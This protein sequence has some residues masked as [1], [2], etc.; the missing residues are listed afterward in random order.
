MG[1][2]PPESA[3]RFRATYALMG[4]VLGLLFPICTALYEVYVTDYSFLEVL[5]GRSNRLMLIIETAPLVLGIVF[6]RLGRRRELIAEEVRLGTCVALAEVQEEIEFY[7]SGL[8]RIASV[9]MTEPS[10][11]ITYANDMFLETSGY[12]REELMGRTHRILNSKEHPSE[13]FQQMWETI[14]SGQVWRGD[15]CNRSKDGQLYWVDST[16][17]PMMDPD[18]SIHQY[19]SIR[20]DISERKHNELALLRAYQEQ[21]IINFLLRIPVA[22]SVSLHEALE[23][24]LAKIISVPWLSL[25]SRGGIFLAQDGELNL[26]VSMGLGREVESRCAKIAS[27]QCLCGRA[28]AGRQ[29]LH[30]S[31]VDERHEVHYEGM[32]P[33][34]HYNVPILNNGVPLGVLVVY[35]PHGHQ[36]H[37][38]DVAFLQ[39]CC[40]VLG[41]L[42]AAHRNETALVRARDEAE[43]ATQAKAR[44]LANMSHEIRT[45]MNGIIGMANLLGGDVVDPTSAERVR[46]I[47]NCGNSLLTLI[48]ELL[49]FSK[50]EVDKIELERIPFNLMKTIDEVIE[51][52]A[53]RASEKGIALTARHAPTVPAGILGDSSR[54]RQIVN[55]LVS[56]AIKFTSAGSVDISTSAIR[57]SGS[58]WTVQVAVSDTGLGIPAD[59]QPRLFQSFSQV[60]AS[61]TRRFGGSGLGLAISKGLCEK[62]GGNMWVESEEGKG[63]T[64]TFTLEAEECDPVAPAMD[65]DPFSTEDAA[66]GQ[67]AP[68]RILLV[69][70]NRINLLVA[71][72]LL[73]RLGYEADQATNGLE[74]L[75]QLEERPYD[76]ILMDCHMPEM[77]GFEATERIIAQYGD[78]RPRIVALTAST[79]QE[80]VDRCYACRMD[81]VLGKPIRV[82]ALSE[83]LRAT[84]RLEEARGQEDVA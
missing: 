76:L 68:L 61:T 50:L 5:L 22:A 31:C 25:L 34:G 78:R 33:H 1:D 28:F 9:S 6:Y 60:D 13:F 51:L 7:K 43:S 82:P 62:M 52:F 74:A 56:N 38:P 59:V 55:N 39:A 20:L 63:S 36:R 53:P 4:V 75:D 67:R 12:S 42:I 79:L 8:D 66:M 72:G 44:F 2:A 40:D 57:T 32:A 23:T 70:D 64:F 30:A 58:S 84:P 81:D 80:D 73:K 41:T 19:A 48:D 27:G 77:D 3:P 35:L 10:G 17:I 26:F 65:S 49:D 54:F 71:A 21:G 45:P 14:T 16:I 69:D 24:A 47:Q 29:P 18:G 83:V 11:R 46:I 37:E 15:I